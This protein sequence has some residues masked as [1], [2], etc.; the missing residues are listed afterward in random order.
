MEN[1]KHFSSLLPMVALRGLVVFPG[2]FI[3]F[4]VGRQKS[5]AAVTKAMASSSREV[6]LIAQKDIKVEEPEKS[7]LYEVGVI[8]TVSQILRI[9]GRENGPVRVAVEGIRRARLC[10]VI[11]DRHM[12]SAVAEEIPEKTARG[13]AKAYVEALIRRTKDLFSEYTEVA[14]QMPADI[15]ATVLSSENPGKLADFIA[16]NIMLD[17]QDRQIILENLSPVKRLEDICVLLEREIEL[18]GLEAVIQ[19]K[20]Q[21]RI[22]EN[23]REYYLHEQLNAINEE[24]GNTEENE[25]ETFRN[26][27]FDMKA[28]D[29]VKEKLKLRQA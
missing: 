22:D 28:P 24:L 18:L 3:H 23:Q 7:D 27:I 19:D 14:P 1:E 6:F 16:G 20:V 4:D 15:S 29:E 8:A 21:S 12:L 5:I 9:S 25:I 2:M 10:D 17:Y 26:K 13:V 11:S